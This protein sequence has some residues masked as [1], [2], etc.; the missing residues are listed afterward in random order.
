MAEE[1]A[2]E[3]HEVEEASSLLNDGNT[4]SALLTEVFGRYHLETVYDISHFKG[5]YSKTCKVFTCQEQDDLDPE[6]KY[7]D[8]HVVITKTCL[9]IFSPVKED[10]V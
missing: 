2:L 4:N 9:L 6:N 8:R 1:S 7:H 3:Q 10:Q 5:K